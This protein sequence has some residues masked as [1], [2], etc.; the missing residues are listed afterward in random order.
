MF[1]VKVHPE[2]EDKE[3]FLED[4]WTL[5]MSFRCGE[6]KKCPND[7]GFH[8]DLYFTH[9]YI[10][11]D[12]K[13]FERRQLYQSNFPYQSVEFSAVPIKLLQTD[14]LVSREPDYEP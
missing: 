14:S 3:T 13:L 6:G 9:F 10:N 4:N 7:A 11:T 12:N 2:T 8:F 1:D 5:E